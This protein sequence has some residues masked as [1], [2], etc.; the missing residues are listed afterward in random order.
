MVIF[1][2][3]AGPVGVVGWVDVSFGVG[4]E[5]E[6][7]AGRIAET[8][9][10]IGGAVGIYGEVAELTV[11]I[12]VAKG[13]LAVVL[14]LLQNG[15]V[16]KAD[17]SLGMGNRQINPLVGI[18][19]DAFIRTR[20]EID[21]AVLKLTGII[22]GDR[23]LLERAVRIAVRQGREESGF[24]QD[25]ETVADPKDELVGVDEFLDRSA[26]VMNQ[27]IG[28]DNAG[29]D[30]VAITESAGDREDLIVGE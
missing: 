7:A 27:L 26:E 24:Y 30:I 1:G 20:L 11:F 9:D 12:D 17:L 28:E 3:G 14:N 2:F 13:D 16:G 8:G 29:G 5:T 6:D 19:K 15:I 18:D 22:D 23:G 10:V 21:P 4:H 25:L